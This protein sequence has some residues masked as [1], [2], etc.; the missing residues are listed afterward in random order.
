MGIGKDD[1]NN[2]KTYDDDENGGVN[3]G[4]GKNGYSNDKNYDN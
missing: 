4:V 1:Y 3:A 2:D